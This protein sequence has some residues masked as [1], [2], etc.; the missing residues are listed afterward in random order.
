MVLRSSVSRR[1]ASGTRSANFAVTAGFRAVV[2][3]LVMEP[4]GSGPAFPVEQASDGLPATSAGLAPSNANIFRRS[5]AIYLLQTTIEKEQ[6]RS[7]LV[8]K[9]AASVGTAVPHGLCAPFINRS[10]HDIPEIGDLPHRT[11]FAAHDNDV[12]VLG[13][14]VGRD[15]GIAGQLLPTRVRL[16]TLFCQ[17]RHHHVD[18]V[19]A[20]KLAGGHFEVF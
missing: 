1:G 20:P 6:R 4:A 18:Q 12:D 10:A 16:N 19:R 2:N 15:Q 9:S 3:P 5:M 8:R 7:W 14:V 13:I 11:G 17:R